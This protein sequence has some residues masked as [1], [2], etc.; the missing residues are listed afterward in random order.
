MHHQARDDRY[1][2]LVGVGVLP[3]PHLA[4]EQIFETLVGR[5][6][7]NLHV[8]EHNSVVLYRSQEPVAAATA[9]RSVLNITE[10]VIA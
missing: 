8:P 10:R 3:A 4:Q 9:L 1:P 2:S 6:A 7:I 5:N